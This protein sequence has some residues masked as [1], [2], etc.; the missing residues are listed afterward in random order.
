MQYFDFDNSLSALKD[1][2]IDELVEEGVGKF[3]YI[4]PEEVTITSREA[5]D[6]LVEN[7]Q[8]NNYAGYVLFFD[9]ATDFCDESNDNSVKVFMNK[10]KA[11]RNAGATII[12]LHHT[13]KKTRA[14]KGQLSLEVPVIMCMHSSMSTKMKAVRL[15]CS[16]KMQQDF[17]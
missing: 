3:D 12:V 2:G 10:L 8:G 15:I 13:N 4:H 7:A 1:R 9:S 16:I 14:I 11:L 5:L 6:K 17:K